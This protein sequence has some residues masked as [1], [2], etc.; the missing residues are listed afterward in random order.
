MPQ[1]VGENA[2]S[3]RLNIVS[4]SLASELQEQKA[5]RTR[6]VKKG[7]LFDDEGFVVGKGTEPNQ[8]IAT[9]AGLEASSPTAMQLLYRSSKFKSGSQFPN[10]GKALLG[11]SSV[12][13][14]V[15]MGDLYLPQ[16]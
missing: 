10:A 9:A 14:T 12:Q 1:I 7:T 5:R 2:G 11:E 6:H 8:L 16:P 4:Q 15:G 13:A 3:I